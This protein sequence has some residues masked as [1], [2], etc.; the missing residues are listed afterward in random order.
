[1]SIDEPELHARLAQ[2]AALAGPQRF[3]AENVA[4]RV[5]RIRRRRRRRTTIA[6]IS[7]AAVAVVA[8]AVAIPLTLAGTSPGT[9]SQPGYG[10]RVS[11]AVTVNGQARA[12]P[13]A[14]LPLFTVTPGERLTITVKVTVPEPH[15][16]TALWLG[17]TNNVFESRPGRP[18]GMKPVLA[19]STRA[20]LRPG[21]HRFVL[22]WTVPAGLTP[23]TTRHLSAESVWSRPEPAE[24]GGDIAE[25]AA[26]LPSG[27]LSP[28]AVA[29]RLRALTQDAVRSCG[30][31][32]PAW[33]RAVRTTF[34]K[35]MAIPDVAQGD[36]LADSADDAVYLVVMKGDFI[37]NDGGRVPSGGC[38]HGP[39]GH[40]FSALFDAAT[41][42]TLEEGLGNRPLGVPLRTLGPVLNLSRLARR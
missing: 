10:P 26:P 42:V 37:F 39:S 30:G 6:A 31:A 18:V 2:T 38:A 32:G 25:F 20:P 19:A 5:R 13:A 16:M 36:N 8:A 33:I 1:M 41:F 3:T 35:A 40:Y 24:E 28:G 7:V 21:A 27:A 23:G 9:I 34:G 17:V 4:A 14:A 29:R 12:V 11:Y 15:A 22:H